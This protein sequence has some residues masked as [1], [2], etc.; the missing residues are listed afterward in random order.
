[1]FSNTAYIKVYMNPLM[2]K[3]LRG[4][5]KIKDNINLPQK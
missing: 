2:A 4:K 5:V 3:Y 1:M